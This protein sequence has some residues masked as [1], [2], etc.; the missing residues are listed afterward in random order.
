MHREA[1][2]HTIHIN[3]FRMARVTLTLPGDVQRADAILI[4]SFLRAAPTPHA[5][6]Q[7]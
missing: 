3:I 5:L 6:C 2:T 4:S 1:H 7:H